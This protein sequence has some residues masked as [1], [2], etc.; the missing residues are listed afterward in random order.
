PYGTSDL[1]AAYKHYWSKDILTKFMNLYLEKYGSPTVKG[2]YKRGTPATSQKELLKVLE[3]IQQETAIV[4][5]E[6]IQVELLEANRGGEAGYL[7]ALE[8][9]D[10][11]IAKAI[12]NQT[13]MTDEGIRVG[14][15]ALA[16]IH[17]EVLKMGLRK[18]KRDLEETIMQEQIIKRLVDFNFNVNS[19]PEFSLGPLEDKDL[20]ILADV[21]SK[22]VNGEIINPDEKWIRQFIGIPEQ[23][24]N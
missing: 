24:N 12:L 23:N 4:I 13:L 3:K 18:I 17:L 5:P 10:K 7:Q 21:V 2:S 16:K 6:D 19:Y 15:F 22:L 1:R 11:Q 9:H 14:S 20:D 8:F